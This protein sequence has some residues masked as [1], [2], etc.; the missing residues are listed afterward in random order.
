MD[1]RRSIAHRALNPF[2]PFILASPGHC[3]LVVSLSSLSKRSIS[4][5][6][7]RISQYEGFQGT[8]WTTKTGYLEWAGQNSDPWA[9]ARFIQSPKSRKLH[10]QSCT[11]CLVNSTPV[12]GREC[13]G[14]KVEYKELHLTFWIKRYYNSPKRGQITEIQT[15]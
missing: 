15:H 11:L 1:L 3:Q 6:S 10:L 5:A 12:M 8:D 14:Q 13:L 2:Y 4:F 9:V 7:Y